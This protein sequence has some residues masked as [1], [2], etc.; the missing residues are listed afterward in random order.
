VDEGVLEKAMLAVPPDSRHKVGKKKKKRKT[1]ENNARGN[2]TTLQ[3]DKRQSRS[4][5]HSPEAFC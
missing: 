4:G 5:I 2:S 1:K 3:V